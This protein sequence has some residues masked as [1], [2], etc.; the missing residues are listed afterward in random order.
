MLVVLPFIAAK[1]VSR[2]HRVNTLVGHHLAEHTYEG[3]GFSHPARLKVSQVAPRR[4][5]GSEHTPTTTPTKLSMEGDRYTAST[6]FRKPTSTCIATTHASEKGLYTSLSSLK[7]SFHH[8]K[9]AQTLAT[10]RSFT[11]VSE[12]FT[13]RSPSPGLCPHRAHTCTRLARLTQANTHTHTHT[14]THKHARKHEYT[15]TC[16]FTA[17]QQTRPQRSTARAT[18]FGKDYFW[19]LFRFKQHTDLEQHTHTHTHTHTHARTQARVH[20]HVHVHRPAA[21]TS[22]AKHS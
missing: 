6:N 11:Y 9:I 5:A 7:T 14:H 16:T 20:S 2:Q 17:Q 13:A 1:G 18:Q 12:Q 19:F 22:A 15:H 21:T 3:L 8:N 10:R 4:P